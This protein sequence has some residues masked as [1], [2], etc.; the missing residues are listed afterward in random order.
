MT[1]APKTTQIHTKLEDTAAIQRLKDE[2]NMTFCR[3]MLSAG[4]MGAFGAT[5]FAIII[6]YQRCS[7]PVVI[8]FVLMC[9][10]YFSRTIWLR[11]KFKVS[12]QA[13]I[14]PSVINPILATIF[15]L[16]VGWSIAAWR[17]TWPEQS[18]TQLPFLLIMVGFI[19][20]SPP[21]MSAK[22]IAGV[23]FIAPILVG[24]ILRL[25]NEDN[26]IFLPA[27]VMV[28]ILAAFAAI[29]TFHYNKSMRS[30]MAMRLEKEA[31]F[32]KLTAAKQR[33]EETANAKSAFLATMSHE[34]RTPINGLMGMLEILKETEL[35]STQANYL[36]TASRSAESLLQL[37]NDI[38]D[39]SKIEVG[40]LE[41]ERV[42]FDWIAMTGEIAIMNRV[43]ATNKGVAFHLDIPSEGT[44]IVLGD[45]IRLRQILNN[46]LSNAFKF[47]SEGHIWLKVS[48]LDDSASKVVLRMSV[49]DTGIGIDE[50]TQHKLFQHFQQ[51]SASTS[52][53]YGGSGL[54]LAISRQLA[55][56]M[57]GD[58]TLASSPGQGSEFILT[59]PFSKASPEALLK[60]GTNNDI[61]TS[62]HFR[63]KVMVVEDDPVSQR[64]AVLMLKSFGI[65][66][67]VVNSGNAAVEAAA[68]ESFDIIFMD[69]HLPDS[70]GFETSGII[71]RNFASSEKKEGAKAPVIVALTGADTPE[72]R[73]RAQKNGVSEFIAK[74]IRKRDMRKCLERWVSNPQQTKTK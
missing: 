19:T 6:L 62:E 69:A 45:S 40:K 2:M 54:G 8:W 38:L 37:L 73:E 14:K 25:Y 59:V 42:P 46:L 70:D 24:I 55:Q 71:N 67:T 31:L 66:P 57:G 27:T 1:D 53:R 30:R 65:T 58:I 43:L 47:T 15:I 61:A 16:G 36:N 33:A 13:C 22:P 10:I 3:Q 17:F 26:Y 4:M 48:I 32:N 72:D 68:K 9:I 51:A 18:I 29:V 49:K 12:P 64:V 44:S 60:F 50:D 74:P 41:L 56:L 20:L 34:I 28:I 39:Y 7:T 11:K 63:A 21:L 35:T 5:L 52:R 23:L